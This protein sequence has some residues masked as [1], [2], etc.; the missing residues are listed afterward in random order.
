M[1]M[2][3]E[4]VLSGAPHPGTDLEVLESGAGFYLGYRDT[5][6]APYSRESRYMPEKLAHTML[7]LLR[8]AS[9]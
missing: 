4:T 6:G 7:Q 8:T 5:D 1:T 3:G 9:D 2:K